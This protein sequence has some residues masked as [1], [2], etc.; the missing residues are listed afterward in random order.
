[1][2]LFYYCPWGWMPLDEATSNAIAECN[3][4]AAHANEGPSISL[5]FAL[6]SI[7]VCVWTGTATSIRR[8]WSLTLASCARCVVF[9]MPPRHGMHTKATI[10]TRTRNGREKTWVF[11]YTYYF[12]ER[13]LGARH[14]MEVVESIMVAAAGAAFFL[15]LL[16]LPCTSA[17][18]PSAPAS[19]C[20]FEDSMRNGSFCCFGSFCHFEEVL[21]QTRSTLA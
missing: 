7:T 6:D 16:S 1:M 10:L 21:H 3:A 17:W 14:K 18:D 5:S 8:G 19:F 20:C 12:S 13:E 9:Q 11:F 4:E 2:P 15:V